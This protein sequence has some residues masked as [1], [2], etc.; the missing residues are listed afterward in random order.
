VTKHSRKPKAQKAATKTQIAQLAKAKQFAEKA[1]SLRQATKFAEGLRTI[2]KLSRYDYDFSSLGEEEG[3]E[4]A[5]FA[6]FWEYRREIAGWCRRPPSWI[7]GPLWEKWKNNR[8]FFPLPYVAL[9]KAGVLN[10]ASTV[11]AEKKAAEDKAEEDWNAAKKKAAEEAAKKK[12]VSP[13]PKYL[14]CHPGWSDTPSPAFRESDL[15]EFKEILAQPNHPLWSLIRKVG[16]VD[17]LDLIDLGNGSY[18][19]RPT[20]SL[21]MHC[22]VLDWGKGSTAVR[23][24]MYAWLQT[25]A[26]DLRNDQPELRGKARNIEKLFQLGAW[27]ARRAGHSAKEYYELRG[28]KR[29]AFGKSGNPSYKAPK[30]F[31]TA[32]DAAEVR[33][34]ALLR[35][36]VTE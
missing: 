2:T 32:A 11:S 9:K 1:E 34:E 30:A 33:L 13:K 24:E 17:P 26:E 5:E 7:E 28:G 20:G 12:A 4:E 22:I 31:R 3:K 6:V 36:K 23:D 25:L 27:R 18:S 10:L 15:E 29:G 21:S 8:R 19:P 35:K 14:T 16:Q